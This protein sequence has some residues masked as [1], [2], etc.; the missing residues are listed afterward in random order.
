[1]KDYITE[2][3]E[4]ME[5][6]FETAEERAANT[7]EVVNH[8]AKKYDMTPNSLRYKLSQEGVYIPKGST[9]VKKE[10]ASSGSKRVSKADAI[11]ALKTAIGA[12][13]IEV[14]D[15]I[16]DKLTGKAAQYFHTVVTELAE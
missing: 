6:Q 1:M 16:C 3:V 2:Y 13:G 10:S 7:V 15:T 11:Q 12:A 14:D 5:N 4:T 8:I 9:G